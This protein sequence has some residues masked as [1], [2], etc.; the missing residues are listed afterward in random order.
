MNKSTLAKMVALGFASSAGMAFAQSSLTLYGNF[1]VAI[2]NVHKGQGY[3]GDNTYLTQTIPTLAGLGVLKAGGSLA[4]ATAA[5]AAA[6]AKLRAAYANPSTLNRVTQSI[7]SQNAIGVKG[8][9]DMGGG[10]K[11]NFVLEGQFASDTG[12][13]SGQDN[14]MWGR[15]AYAG[16]TTPFGEIRA[17]RQYAPM[18]YTFALSTV[19][20]LGASDLMGFGLVVNSLQNRQ[21]NQISYWIRNGGLTASVAYSP[22]AGVDKYISSA[23]NGVASGSANGQII[24][25][26]NAGAETTG[27]QGRG[28]S[29]GFFAN[30]AVDS[31]LNVTGAYHTNKFGDASVVDAST[32][33]PLV[34][35]DR[36][37]SIA[38]GSKY[39][40]PST[41]TVFGINYLYSKFKNDATSNVDSI[42][43][44][45][46]AFGVKHPIDQFAVGFEG[47]YSQFTNFTKGK[48]F[49][50]MFSGDYNFSK[51][52]RLYTRF[53][54]LKDLRGKPANLDTTTLP[55]VGA[56]TPAVTGGPVPI[57][58]GFGSTELPFF[59]GGGANIDSTSRVFSIGVRHEF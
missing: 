41:G 52:T 54:M 6:A 39:K 15:Q 3:I 40:A 25:A 59:A 30:Y 46:V 20:I 13:Q 32:A 34:A 43:M 1:D 14:R 26:I 38:L 53:G 17:G 44:N 8:V 55:V 29:L 33:L 47:A 19:E 56:V 10:Y 16:L 49:A 50:L 11:G 58:T 24:G 4:D 31:S 35:L 12:A 36:Y 37:Y 57:L 21:D 7:S 2:D 28:Q 9:E 45:T 5:Q 48:D 27:A 22:N 42:Q 23:R 18:F 51:R